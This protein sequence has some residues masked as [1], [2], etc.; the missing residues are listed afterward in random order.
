VRP[1]RRTQTGGAAARLAADRP[2][3]NA[4]LLD[5]YF[6]GFNAH[7]VASLKDVIAENYVQRDAGQGSG[8]AGMQAACQRY[9]DMLPDFHLTL[10]DS[11]VTDDKIVARF[12]ITATH[13]H[14]VR[15][16]PNAPVFPP[17]GKKLALEGIS[18]GRVA[19]GKF[20]E[21][22]DVDDLL[23]AAQQM[24]VQPPDETK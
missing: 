19:G 1:L 13:D 17:T 7:D 9:F 8:L 4:A 15:L 12:R 22:W 18:I 6:A 11:V 14:P 5:K 23:S 16:V 2:A 21:H 10:E 20:V 3:D 24:Y